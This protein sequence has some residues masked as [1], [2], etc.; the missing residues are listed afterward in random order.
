MTRAVTTSRTARRW[1]VVAA[2]GVLVVDLATTAW[3]RADLSASR[4]HRLL[5]G[6]VVLRL[7]ANHGATLGLGAA[8][9]TLVEVA[10]VAALALLAVLARRQR[11]V[12]AAGLGAAFGGGLGNLVVRLL[13]PE[14]P[15]T[16]PVV[17]WVH[18]AP[19]P[20]TFNLAD[21]AVRVGLVVAVIG[22]L[23]RRRQAPLPDDEQRAASAEHV[24]AAR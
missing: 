17:D 22:A 7:V 18:V 2:V 20:P 6:L 4:A 24:P 21:V 10:E 19:Y 3:A 15:L 11:P 13:G 5:G 12:V 8:H 16:S 14:G 23:A 9:E 1:W